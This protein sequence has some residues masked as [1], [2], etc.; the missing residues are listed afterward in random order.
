MS[1]HEPERTKRACLVDVVSLLILGSL[2]VLV[3]WAAT[4]RGWSGP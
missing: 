3:W 1:H 4:S 2:V